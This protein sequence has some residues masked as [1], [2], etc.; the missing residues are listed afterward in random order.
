MNFNV[1]KINE[2]ILAHLIMYKNY[3]DPQFLNNINNLW[4]SS[5]FAKSL[6]YVKLKFIS[7]T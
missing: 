4:Q 6:C 2:K 5:T 1:C 3:H 7:V